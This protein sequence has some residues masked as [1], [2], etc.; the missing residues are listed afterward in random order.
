[1]NAIDFLSS[2]SYIYLPT[3]NNPKVILAVD[4]AKMSTNSF[5]LY[6]PFSVKAKL[7]KKISKFTCTYSNGIVRLFL[8]KK[9]KADF[10]NYLENILNESLVVSVYFGT[11]LDKVV[12][13]LQ[14]KEAKIIGYV[15]YPLNGIGKKHLENEKKAF[16]ILSELNIIDSYLLYDT[17]NS[18]PFLLLPTLDGTIDVI[19]NKDVENILLNFKRSESYTLSKHPRIISLKKLLIINGMITYVELLKNIVTHSQENYSLVYEH[20]D[21]APWN[22]VKTKD[23]C[24]AFD[25][26]YFTEEGLEY[27]DL[28]K[29]YYQIGKLLNNLTGIELITYV[30]RNIKIKENVELFKIFLLKEIVESKEENILREFEMNILTILDKK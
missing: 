9:E 15:K 14:T 16:E 30:L 18:T 26:E 13:Q 20:G 25:F 10:I 22:I 12:L 24:V 8:D 2:N 23:T 29:Y 5:K 4:N 21:F 7:L 28:Y 1:M 19:E 3:K 17:Y 11:I 27:L 6:N